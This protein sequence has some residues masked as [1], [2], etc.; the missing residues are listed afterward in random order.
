[1]KKSIYIIL[2]FLLFGF[3]HKIHSQGISTLDSKLYEGLEFNMSKLKVPHFPKLSVSITEFG[4]IGDGIFNNSKAFSQAI[5]SVNSKGG[6]TVEVPRGIWFTG[7]IVL[8]SNVNLHLQEGALVLFSS[9]LDD[10]S[11]VKTSFEG[12][13]TVRNQS[14]ISATNAENI[15]ITGKGIIDGSGDAWRPVKKGKM[16][17]ANWENLVNSGGVLSDDK[18]MWFPSES[19]KKGFN[20]SS[21]FNVPDL[22]DEN[23]LKSVKDF[24][25]PVMVS[26]RNCKN[27]LLD[28]PTFQNSPAWNIH[29]LM[30]ENMII[31]NL[32]VRNP[33]YSQN[34][35]GLDLESCR[36]VFIYNNSFDVGDDAICLKSGK[37]EAGRK[38]GMPTENVVI[39]NNTVYHAHGGFVV[40]S[41]MSGGIKN[42]HVSKCTFVG[43]D[44]G[45]RFK[46]TRGRGGVVENIYIS[47]INMVNIG[48]EAVRFNMFYNGN[49]PVLD[50]DENAKDEERD[51]SLEPV[52]EE[53]PIFRNIYMKNISSTGSKKAAIIV[54]LPEMKLE[55]AHLE[56]SLFEAEEGIT[57]IDAKDIGLKNVKVL[58]KK[59]PALVI[60]NSSDLNFKNFSFNKI[61][62][63]PAIK[64]LGKSENID[65][66]KSEISEAEIARTIEKA[67]AGKK[68]NLIE[69]KTSEEL[70][71]AL[72]E[73]KPG[74]S[75]VVHAGTYKL[76][77]RFYIND[78]GESDNKIYLIGDTSGERPLLD[79]S[80]MEENSSNQ[81]I[82]L[83]ADN[84][85][86]K[87]LRIYNAGDNGMQVRG[88]DNIIEFCSFS[89]CSDTGLQLDDG[90]SNNTILNCDS[91]YNADSKLENADGFA[92]KMDVGSGNKFIGCRSWNNL[93]DGWDGYLREAD[94]I[95]TTYEHCWSF[96]NGYL[97]DGTKGKGDGNGFKTGGS[98]NKA[99][100][101]NAT[102][103]RCISVHNVA[104]GFDH[105]SNRGTVKIL[106]C[107]ATGNGRNLAFAEKNQLEKIVIMNTLVLGEMG[108]YN[109]EVE[110]VENNSWQMDFKINENDFVS[111]DRS[112]LSAPRKSDGSLPDIDFMRP[113]KN[114]KLID[115][116]EI[117]GRSYEGKA[118]DLGAIEVK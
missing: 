65:F 43:T 50:P 76:D 39:K 49:S 66:S 51:E 115:A 78:S 34:G 83:K 33:W 97:K 25:R 71:A 96:N 55:N 27:V 38:R 11:L 10:Y 59:G 17:P 102:Y 46:S 101:H 91:F 53:T 41:E 68:K 44:S 93:D 105:N 113:K 40:G 57:I 19:S 72:D 81:G 1:M 22:I 82:V 26:I 6:G 114:S 84:W 86:L 20:S 117:L 63:F 67:S 95:E 98:D 99:R 13:N 88:N 29:P 18:K 100:K 107:S 21:N 111:L 62:S 69:V 8:K 14:P 110:K 24:L 37:D 12:L 109:A 15:A 92:V 32:T 48:S 9:N 90:A 35:D 23:K 47:N 42:I 61:E 94:N 108:K 73:P 52:T 70:R 103:Y 16:A 64:I 2:F 45:L 104:D 80:A 28:G 118:P 89:E 106:N 77:E 54:G 112:Q 79:F 60:Y 75:I 30:S 31:R 3:H 87:G 4:A 85:H 36:N 7:P 56:N 74:D 5:S 58:R 116:G